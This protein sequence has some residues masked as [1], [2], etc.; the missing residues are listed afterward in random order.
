MNMPRASY[1][2]TVHEARYP[3]ARDAQVTFIP[4]A[5]G[6][7]QPLCDPLP[8]RRFVAYCSATR[9]QRQRRSGAS[10]L[11]NPSSTVCRCDRRVGADMDGTAAEVFN[12]QKLP[13]A[14][15]RRSQRDYASAEQRPVRELI[16]KARESLAVSPACWPS[17]SNDGSQAAG[18]RTRLR[19]LSKM[20]SP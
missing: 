8:F 18:C 2:A 5:G 19:T 1:T 4:R 15:P 16:A 10:V 11:L 6:W 7:S 3:P 20:C 12:R 13:A 17:C 9:S 14:E